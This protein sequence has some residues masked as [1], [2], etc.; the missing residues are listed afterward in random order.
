[1]K[2]FTKDSLSKELLAICTIGWVQSCKGPKNDGAVG[3]TVEQ[4]LDIPENNLKL[5]DAGEFEIKGQRR[6]Q[7]LLTL[8]H[9]DPSPRG[10]RGEGLF[11]TFL[12]PKYGWPLKGHPEEWSFRL[13]IGT[14]PPVNKDRDRGFRITLNETEERLALSFNANL[15][16]DL[17]KGWLKTVETRIGLGEINPQP[18]WSLDELKQ[19]TNKLKNAFY[20]LAES[21]VQGSVEYFWYD[22]VIVLEGFKFD[23]FLD[24]LRKGQLKV[25]FDARTGYGRSAHNHGTK[26]RIPRDIL[27]SMYEKSIVL[28]DKPI[29]PKEL[30]KMKVD[31]TKVHVVG[32]IIV[33]N[34]IE[35]L[36]IEPKKTE[37]NGDKPHQEALF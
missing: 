34:G 24:F 23:V 31:T 18:Y 7:S 6:G 1:M 26:F 30:R 11:N 14:V 33:S 36:I 15:T 17:Q 35:E 28:L 9:L 25:D 10:K 20:I 37:D 3:N 21:K 22:G 8:F 12:L 29:A 5:A 13:T 32:D 2:T 27:P 4:L 19:A 16:A